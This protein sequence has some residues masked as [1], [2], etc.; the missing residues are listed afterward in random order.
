MSK[1][2]NKDRIEEASRPS[3]YIDGYLKDL[4]DSGKGPHYGYP[5]NHLPATSDGDIEVVT[6]FLA[7][8]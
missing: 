4:F 1:Q 8:Q 7:G 2:A 5:K 6:G 3:P